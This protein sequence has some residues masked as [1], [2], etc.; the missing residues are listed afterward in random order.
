MLSTLISN[1]LDA[2]VYL[3]GIVFALTVHEYSHAWV[4]TRSGD[5]TPRLMGRLN[6]NPASHIDPLGG[7]MFILL[8]FGWGKPV[9]YN[10]LR[11]RRRVDEL[12]I[13]LA[14]PVANLLSALVIRLVIIGLLSLNFTGEQSILF[15]R[16]LEI[17]ATVNVY[18]AAFNLLPVPPLDG[19][20]IL[21]Y[22]YPPFRGVFASQIGLML[23]LLLILPLGGQNLL[24]TIMNPLISLLQTLTLG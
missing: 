17:V 23:I 9:V 12:L 3:L 4:A 6:L 7:L 15:L 11:L 16:F 2:F 14:G 24:G 21:A 10:P 1:P 20:S 18:L 13:A 19:S 22:F 5:D 8:G